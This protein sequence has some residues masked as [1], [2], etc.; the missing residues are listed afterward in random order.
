MTSPIRVLLIEDDDDDRLI[1]VEFLEDVEG[2]E[3]DVTWVDTAQAGIEMLAKNEHD[4]CLLDYRLGAMT[5]LE[6]L[7]AV[8]ELSPTPP[9]ILLTGQNDAETDRAATEAGATDFLVKGDF[10]GAELER[11]MRYSIGAAQSFRS[12]LESE[13]RF[14]TVVEAA[15]DGIALVDANSLLIAANPAAHKMF[16]MDEGSMLGTDIRDY[17]AERDI[18]RVI[19]LVSGNT[20]G[21]EGRNGSYK[22]TGVRSGSETFPIEFSVS[23]WRSDQGWVWSI[24]VRDVTEQRRLMEELAHA[25]YHDRLTG[26]SNRNFLRQQISHVAERFDLHEPKPA[27]LLL[28]LDD[29]KR[30]NDADGHEVGDQLLRLVGQRLAGCVRGSETIARLGGDEFALFVDDGGEPANLLRLADRILVELAEPFRI[31]TRFVAVSGSIGI[32]SIDRADMEADELIRNADMAMYAAKAR[33]KS[34]Y[35]QFEQELE[36]VVLDQISLED[37]LRDAVAQEL[38]EPHFQPIVDL[39]TGRTL[40]FEAL[41]RWTH[42]TKGPISPDDFIAAAERI[43][44][45]GLLDRAI[46]R[47]AV[48]HATHWQATAIGRGVGLSVNVSSAQLADPAFIAFVDDVL[49]QYPLV[50]GTLSIEIT[51][52]V[53]VGDP[54][55]V[56]AQLGLLRDRQIKIA[57]DDFGTGYSSL[58]YLRQL[59]IDV[60]KL[61]R[62]FVNDCEREQGR[63]LAEA[64]ARLSETLRLVTVAEGI[65]TEDQRQLLAYLGYARGQGY[66]FA[67]PMPAGE[68]LDHLESVSLTKTPF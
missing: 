68:I 58:S 5:G 49:E 36:G 32:A 6:V 66:L 61:D 7:D 21:D 42:P 33:G 64:V 17:V 2:I 54:E 11:A 56:I 62:S 43:G 47:R 16:G 15:S 28:D 20:S 4:V 23:S 18:E 53:M 12:L 14:R 3:Y 35:E 1:A 51:E 31:G 30:I 9:C 40:A 8:R 50:P 48:E 63:A 44:I 10:T 24:I 60:L 27:L 41:A 38:I 45:I 59:P 37:D 52:S 29:F 26:L 65:E 19:R 67:R 13:A 34:C 39:G 57:M 22:A 55:P 25:A 46:F